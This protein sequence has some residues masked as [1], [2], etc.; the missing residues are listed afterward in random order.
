M[1]TIALESFLPMDSQ[2]GILKWKLKIL[3]QTHSMVS[4]ILLNVLFP[5][6]LLFYV[7]Q[8][9]SSTHTKHNAV[10][11][12]RSAMWTKNQ[13]LFGASIRIRVQDQCEFL[14]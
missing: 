7:K 2:I 11:L 4:A 14:I 5:S 1:V 10:K 12:H 3:S 13:R 9:R 8:Q 6:M